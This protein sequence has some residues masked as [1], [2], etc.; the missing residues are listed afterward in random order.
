MSKKLVVAFTL[1]VVSGMSLAEDERIW[2]CGNTKDIEK[3]SVSI[4][5]S[6]NVKESKIGFLETLKATFLNQYSKDMFSSIKVECNN[7][8]WLATLVTAN[9]YEDLEDAKIF[10]NMEAILRYRAITENKEYEE[11]RKIISYQFD[12][13]VQIDSNWK[14]FHSFAETSNIDIIKSILDGM[15]K[16]KRMKYDF[17]NEHRVIIFDGKSSNYVKEF[18]SLCRDFGY[19]LTPSK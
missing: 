14:D 11:K 4:Y 17:N 8:E 15:E 3:K 5:C 7:T 10:I 13:N 12:N 19:T 2:S 6:W 18:I 1:F 9:S 16:S